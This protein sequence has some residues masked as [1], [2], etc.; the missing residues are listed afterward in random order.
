MDLLERCR[1]C[2][3]SSK[4]IDYHGIN[5]KASESFT[6]KEIFET[7][8][9]YPILDWEPQ[10]FCHNCAQKLIEWQEFKDLCEQTQ[11]SLFTTI[12][13]EPELDLELEPGEITTTT[14]NISDENLIQNAKSES[15]E[16]ILDEN[17]IKSED[18]STNDA[19]VPLNIEEKYRTRRR[20][21]VNGDVS[22][23]IKLEMYIRYYKEEKLSE[24]SFIGVTQINTTLE[25]TMFS[26]KTQLWMLIKDHLIREICFTDQHEPKWA[27]NKEV[28]DFVDMAKFIE[29]NYRYSTYSLDVLTNKNLQTWDE[30]QIILNIYPYS[31]SIKTKPEWIKVTQKLFKFQKMSIEKKPE[32]IIPSNSSNSNIII[33]NSS[34]NAQKRRIVLTK[35]QIFKPP[36]VRKVE[37]VSKTAQ[38]DPSY[39]PLVFEGYVFNY[40]SQPLSE[41]KYIGQVK[42]NKVHNKNNFKQKMWLLLCNFVISP[43]MFKPNEYP[44]PE[45]FPAY[46]DVSEFVQFKMPGVDEHFLW[47]AVQ[48]NTLELWRQR[49]NVQ[50]YF[51]PFSNDVKTEDDYERIVKC[52]L[53]PDEVEK[54][55]EKVFKLKKNDVVEDIVEP[56]VKIKI[57]ND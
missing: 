46:H 54:R 18:E 22:V 25:K 12:K 3:T 13:T 2:K 43:R 21:R 51:Y 28:V 27:S 40:T 6:F 48:M 30:K 55:I 32:P 1:S 36:K 15:E 10:E 44:F 39:K 7:S 37:S 14:N 38:E 24:K 42:F 47:N 52:F 16:Q 53:D 5:T 8:I 31:T 56:E 35:V 33:E 50:I 19:T 34:K 26:F 23:D 29:F 49:N 57:E 20:P 9:G 17:S 41:A 11:V 45:N 4:D